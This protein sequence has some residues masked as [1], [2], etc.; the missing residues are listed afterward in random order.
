MIRSNEDNVIF[1]LRQT[2][3]LC[4][5]YVRFLTSHRIYLYYMCKGC[6]TEPKVYRHILKTQNVP[7]DRCRCNYKGS[8]SPHLLKDPECWSGRGLIQRPFPAR[9]TGAHTTEVH[10]AAA[11][12]R[13]GLCGALNWCYI[14]LL[15][16][17]HFQ[18]RQLINVIGHLLRFTPKEL[19]C[20]N[21]AVEWKVCVESELFGQ[22]KSTPCFSYFSCS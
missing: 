1:N 7:S 3:T 9:Q 11:V 16:F 15:L 14:T 5:Q 6:E 17:S 21:E 19:T 22:L 12:Y 2:T 13:T 18:S 8:T 20:V 4:E 10:Q